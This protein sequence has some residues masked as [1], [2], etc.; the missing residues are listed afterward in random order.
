MLYMKVVKSESWVHITRKTIFFV[1]F[2]LYLYEVM[3]VHS[4]N[5]FMMF[6]S[7][8]IIPYTLNLYSNEY[9]FYL[10]KTENKKKAALEITLCI[11]YI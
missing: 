4:D 1:S 10:N 9:Q 8:I 3:D 7:Q 5:C 2:I 6:V 11:K